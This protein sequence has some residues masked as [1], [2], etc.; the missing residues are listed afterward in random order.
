[1]KNAAGQYLQHVMA[2]TLELFVVKNAPR[3]MQSI[4]LL[5]YQPHDS[6]S[7]KKKV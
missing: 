2:G 5:S 6:K 1:M 7:N 4:F 3:A